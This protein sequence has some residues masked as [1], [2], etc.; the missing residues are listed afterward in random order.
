MPSGG[1]L[2]LWPTNNDDPNISCTDLHNELV[3]GFELSWLYDIC[4]SY[5]PI[6][7]DCHPD[8]ANYVQYNDDSTGG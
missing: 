7:G 4:G 5:Y 3:Y 2:T 1:L 8:E 6:P